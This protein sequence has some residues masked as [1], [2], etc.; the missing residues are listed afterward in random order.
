MILCQ[1]R[2]AY[3]LQF[4]NIGNYFSKDRILPRKLS[5]LYSPG[6]EIEEIPIHTK[7][8]ESNIEKM[9]LNCRYKNLDK[10]LCRTIYL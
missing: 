2:R 10:F 1:L 8:F 4:E 7:L 3:I 6:R 9:D 5:H